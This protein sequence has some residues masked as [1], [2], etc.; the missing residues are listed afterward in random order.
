[1]D[2]LQKNFEYRTMPFGELLDRVFS[3]DSTGITAQHCFGC[4]EDNW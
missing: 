3:P 2:F 1:M 4:L